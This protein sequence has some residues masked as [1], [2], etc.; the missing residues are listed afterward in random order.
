MP[1]SL[2]KCDSKELWKRTTITNAHIVRESAKAAMPNR[3]PSVPT[4]RMAT[5][6]MPPPVPTNRRVHPSGP[7]TP[8]V[9]STLLS[10]RRKCRPQPPSLTTA[11]SDSTKTSPT[12][13]SAPAAKP[14]N[15]SLQ[16]V[17]RSTAKSSPRWA[18]RYMRA[19]W[20][21]TAARPS[22]PSANATSSSTSPKGS[23]PPSTTPRSGRPS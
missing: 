4:A 6:P 20:S 7:K 3:P 14:T 21:T 13:A 16:E 15:S 9:P 12:P 17:S 5:D 11:P 19:T 23:S 1:V 22:A 10:A 18:S 8:T 2:T